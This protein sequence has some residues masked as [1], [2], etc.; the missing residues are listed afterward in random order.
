MCNDSN[1]T[2]ET[3]GSQ[4]VYEKL[5]DP[6]Q[7]TAKYKI[8]KFTGDIDGSVPTWG[9]LGWIDAMNWPLTMDLSQYVLEDGTVGGYFKTY[10]VSGGFTYASVHKAGHMVPQFQPAKAY[11]LIFRWLKDTLTP[12]IPPA[13]EATEVLQN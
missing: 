12:Y 3:R 11:N 8:L 13:P 6:A 2:I 10:N 7:T 1:Y 4:W 5:N 9:T